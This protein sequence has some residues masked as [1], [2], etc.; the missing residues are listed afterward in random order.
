MCKDVLLLWHTHH[1]SLAHP[2]TS[3]GQ[4]CWV[5]TSWHRGCTTSNVSASTQ[6]TCKLRETRGRESW[7]RRNHILISKTTRDNT[8]CKAIRTQSS[9][10]EWRK[11]LNLGWRYQ[12]WH[13]V[14]LGNAEA[15]GERVFPISSLSLHTRLPDRF[16]SG[17]LYSLLTVFSV[18]QRS[19]VLLQPPLPWMSPLEP[20]AHT[21][22]WLEG[23]GPK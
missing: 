8:K 17:A 18:S 22:H 1:C 6:K 13:W 12:L 21:Q 19:A 14:H 9:K 3:P 15:V 10:G 16:T 7:Q 20:A 5:K 23:S 2:W 11:W 4:R